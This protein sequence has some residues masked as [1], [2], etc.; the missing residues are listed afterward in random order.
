MGA[1]HE[2]SGCISVGPP[3]P[4]SGGLAAGPGLGPC[5]FASKWRTSVCPGPPLL[6]RNMSVSHFLDSVSWA[7]PLPT[8][9]KSGGREGRERERME[10]GKGDGDGEERRGKERRGKGVYRQ[11]K[12]D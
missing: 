12:G 1:R 4:F 11:V 9:E 7:K 6:Q 5:L 8:R 2:L 3:R 10:E